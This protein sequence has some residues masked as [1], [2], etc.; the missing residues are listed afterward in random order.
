MRGAHP[1][2]ME[3]LMASNM[4]QTPGYGVDDYTKRA[5]QIIL[6]AC[7][8]SEG[9]VHFLVGGTQTN[10]TV[11]DGILRNTQ[12]VLCAESAHVNVHE[13]GAIE[14]SGH[15]VLTMPGRDGK[16]SGRQVDEYLA[17][18][19]ADET[20]NHMVLPG[21]VYISQ[22]TELGTLYSLSELEELSSVCRRWKLPLFV[23]GA[24]LVYGLQSEANDVTLQELARL[25]DVFYIGGTKA[26]LLFGEAVVLPHPELIPGFFTLIKQHGALLAKGRL[27]GVQFAAL[28][29]DG[30][31]EEMGRNAIRQAM[32]L[33]EAFVARGYRLL[34]DSPT[35]QQFVVLPNDVVDRLAP[36][37]GFEY[38][39]PRGEVFSAVRFVTDWATSDLEIAELTKR[40]D[41]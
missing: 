21:M 14:A 35:N 28:F 27:L 5:E 17:N 40:L 30:L 22:P 41:H 24:R 13:A 36:N 20:W 3:A 8:L 15:K 26:G 1:R 11:I 7:G 6:D 18:F 19:Y 4:V 37:V 25:A 33:R 2:V 12:G 23:D 31:Y 16:I 38:W 9:K 34:M 32:K 10:A 29:T 39:G